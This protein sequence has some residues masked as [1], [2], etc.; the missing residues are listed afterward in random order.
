MATKRTIAQL[1]AFFAPGQDDGAITPDRVQDLLFSLQGGWGRINLTGSPVQTEL[2]VGEWAKVSGE[3]VLVAHSN[4]FT[5]PA[6]NRLQCVCP[7]PSV[8]ECAAVVT[9]GSA[10]NQMFELALARNGDVNGATVTRAR[11]AAGGDAVTVPLMMD[12]VQAANDYA[13]VWI[14]NLTSGA[15]P[16]ITSLHLRARTYVQ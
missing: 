1:M 8:M 4:Q 15:N 16:T 13:E 6:N 12:F 5:M 14:R 7:V 3:T 9:L 2:T 11:I 10:P